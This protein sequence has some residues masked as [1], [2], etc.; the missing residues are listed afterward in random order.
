MSKEK[1]PRRPSRLGGPLPYYKWLVLD[2]R[3]S[4]NAN[5]LGYIA[6]GLYRELLDECW[7]EGHIPDD[8]AK[9][10][11][12]CRCPMSVMQREW[13]RLRTLFVPVDGDDARLT[14]AKLE[15]QRTETDAIRVKRAMARTSKKREQVITLLPSSS[16]KHE[17]IA[18]STVGA[19]RDIPTAAALPAPHG[20]ARLS[21]VAPAFMATVRAMRGGADVS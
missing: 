3:A 1:K 5:A 4:R 17:Q 15:C 18:G 11:V 9:L 10:A 21:E 12:I 20:A 16:S 14:N 2:Y 13:V 8:I 19:T 6:R 7:M